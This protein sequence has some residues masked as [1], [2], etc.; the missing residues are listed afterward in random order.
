MGNCVVVLKKGGRVTVSP[1]YQML[2]ALLKLDS[3]GLGGIASILFDVI[4]DSS[5]FM[6]I[7]LASGFTQLEIAEEDK[8]KTACRDARGDV[9]E[10]NRCGFGLKTIPSGFAA[11]VGEALGPLKG[12]C[13]E[14]A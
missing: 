4:R 14:L 6:P 13:P 2:N 11:Y 8:H 7:D 3:G 10:F 12:R 1:E 5:C 9:W